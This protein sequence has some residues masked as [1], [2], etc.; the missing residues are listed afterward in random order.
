MKK[1]V[2]ITGA[3]GNLGKATVQRF[4]ADGYQVIAILLPGDKLRYDTGGEV[5]IYEAD[6]SN[7]KEVY[8]TV[9]KIINEHKIID[10]ALLLAGGYVYGG[11]SETDENVLR[12][13]FA[14]NFATAFYVVRPVFQQM[15]NQPNGGRLVFV[16]AK[17]TLNPEEGKN[18]LAYALSKSLLFRLADYLNAEGSSKNVC[19]SVVAPSIIDTAVNRKDMPDAD[20]SKWVKPE[21]IADAMAFLCS[22]KGSPL[23]ETVLK[24]YGGL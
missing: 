12:K 2:L 18:S 21:Q 15:M 20:F 4:V 1:N 24:I 8:D 17:P 9:A 14:L 11:I 3:S 22:D 13:M 19:A 7:E 5:K 16:G 10:A 6:L 23:R